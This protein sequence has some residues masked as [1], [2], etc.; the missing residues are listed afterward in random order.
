MSV[1]QNTLSRGV[2]R[3]LADQPFLQHQKMLAHGF[4][5]FGWIMCGDCIDE[6]CV[7]SVRDR[8]G[9]VGAARAFANKLPGLVLANPVDRHR[10]WSERTGYWHFG[11][12]ADA[13]RRPTARARRNQC[14]RDIFIARSRMRAI[15]S[16]SWRALRQVVPAAARCEAHLHDL[17]E[18]GTG[19]DEFDVIGPA[20]R[21]AGRH[22]CRSLGGARCDPRLP[23]LR[24]HAVQNGG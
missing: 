16:A 18:I 2:H 12:F 24:A 17:H 5:R 23:I 21:L 19:N 9:V 20:I 10:R 13:G 3:R 1:A 14:F 11:R 7:L 4:A 22:R 6:R 15:S 8:Q